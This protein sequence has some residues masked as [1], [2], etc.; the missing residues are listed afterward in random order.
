MTAGTNRAEVDEVE[1]LLRSQRELSGGRDVYDGPALW[2]ALNNLW[3]KRLKD[4][5]SSL[6]KKH[7]RELKTHKRQLMQ[8][9]PA[10]TVVAKARIN[11]LKHDLNTVRSDHLFKGSQK[12]G[13][14]LKLSLA[15]VEQLSKQ[16]V[17]VD[18]DN[19]ALR[20]ELDNCTQDAR[21]LAR[22]VETDKSLL[23]E[24]L[25]SALHFHADK[26]RDTVAGHT[27]TLVT[28]TTASK[29]HQGLDPRDVNLLCQRLQSA[30]EEN[31]AFLKA[32]LEVAA[33]G[34][35]GHQN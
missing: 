6:K 5:T 26:L 24:H 34:E 11:R 21:Q 14:L 30:V 17:E 2:L 35:R 33:P 20:A 28:L 25:G 19:Q 3:K 29:R 12:G 1:A 23:R 8:Q 27:H 4:A 10:S 7:A 16:V 18:E 32:R 9:L 13:Q 22:A 31:M 15:T